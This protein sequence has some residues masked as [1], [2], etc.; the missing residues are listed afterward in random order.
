MPVA[1]TNSQV[2]FGLLE[3][4][5]QGPLLVTSGT[6]QS[7][8]IFVESNLS[9]SMEGTH[10][11]F[12][13]RQIVQGRLV[14]VLRGEGVVGDLMPSPLPEPTEQP[15]AVYCVGDILFSLMFLL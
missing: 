4:K 8:I 11:I 13:L 6:A 9:Y 12:L 1:G 15:E 7:S 5:A 3:Q 2:V 14:L 10:L